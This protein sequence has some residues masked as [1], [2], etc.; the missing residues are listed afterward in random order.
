MKRSGIRRSG[1]NGRQ[2]IRRK[3]MTRRRSGRLSASL[4]TLADSQ[5]V[6]WERESGRC[7]RCDEQGEQVHHRRPRG[8][9]G[10]SRS[11]VV[12]N[13]SNLMLVCS[14]CH[15]WLESARS[16]AERSGWIVRHGVA[17]PADVPLMHAMLGWV[18]LDDDGNVTPVGGPE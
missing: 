14:P 6:V 4:R 16:S 18:L 11:T 3:R 17:R 5:L 7:I 10:A 1:W 13:L 15:T 9:G 2:Q 12:H 8:I